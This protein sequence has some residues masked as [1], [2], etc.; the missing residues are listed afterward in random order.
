ME[1]TRNIWPMVLGGI[2]LMLAVVTAMFG[3]T[4]YSL[5]G[6]HDAVFFVVP[7]VSFAVGDGLINPLTDTR[8]SWG[9]PTGGDRYLYFPPLWALLVSSLTSSAVPLPYPQQVMLIAGL[10]AALMVL[11]IAWLFARVATLNNRPLTGLSTA[12]IVIALCIMLRAVWTNLAR[13]E[14]LENLLLVAACLIAF[15]ARRPREVIAGFAVAL[16]LMP[17]IHPFGAMFAPLLVGLY[18]SFRYP[19]REALTK[20]A[21]VCGL[22]LIVYM[23]V[24]QLSPY[25]IAETLRGVS[26]HADLEVQ[27]MDIRATVGFLKSPYALAY[28][29]VMTFLVAIGTRFFMRYRGAVRSLPLFLLFAAGVVGLMAQMVVIGMKTYYAILF[30]TPIFAAIIYYFVHVSP[31]GR[32]KYAA[33]AFLALFAAISL[34]PV[35]AFPEYLS[36][37]MTIEAAREKFTA[38]VKEYPVAEL[39]VGGNLWVLSEEYRRMHYLGD[40]LPSDPLSPHRLVVLDRNYLQG[41]DSSVLAV[42][43]EAEGCRLIADHLT[44]GVPT[45][46]SLRLT[47]TMPGYGFAV[48]ACGE[49]ALGNVQIRRVSTFLNN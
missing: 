40:I 31:P 35:L 16:G 34:R 45:F 6:Y 19:W 23:L 25:S 15:S 41:S 21:A 5:N 8:T 26:R 11:L 22:A 4:G 37:G 10:V 27:R 24:M 12:L 36:G 38:I 39:Y 3:A 7:G 14:N 49:R 30:I 32:L 29:V 43:A 20:I 13:P 47:R 42:P 46:I 17:A 2:V 48:Y 33:L 9:D 28:V 18:F 1:T 44:R